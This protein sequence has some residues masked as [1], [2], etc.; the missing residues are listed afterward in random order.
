MRCKKTIAR[1]SIGFILPPN[2]LHLRVSL[3]EIKKQFQIAGKG[4]HETFEIAI[5]LEHNRIAKNVI[6][7]HASENGG[8]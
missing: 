1:H 6:R 7:G 4:H 5:L 8:T 3:N 2:N